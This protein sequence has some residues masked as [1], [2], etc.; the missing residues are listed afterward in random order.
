M[1]LRVSTL[2]VAFGE[3]VVLRIFDPDMLVQDLDSLGFGHDELEIFEDFIERP[4]GI[5]LV[6]GPTG[7]GRPRPSTR[8]SAPRQPDVNVTT[9]EDPIEMVSRASTRSRFS[10]DR[11]HL[12][13]A[14]SAPSCGRTRTSSWSARSGT[15]RPPKTP[16]R[17]R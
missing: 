6:T 14:P 12:R 8:P 5:I 17:R 9:I 15:R 7:T 4:H 13:R 3:K 2:P 1:E 16:S 11:A 10:R